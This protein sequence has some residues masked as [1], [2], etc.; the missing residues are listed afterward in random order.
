MGYVRLLIPELDYALPAADGERVNI[1]IPLDWLPF[2]VHTLTEITNPNLHTGGKALYLENLAKI[3]T[4]LADMEVTP[5]LRPWLL[6]VAG[7]SELGVTTI[8]GEG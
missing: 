5:I 2:V 4:V 6:G 3:N 8:L 1:S 7:R